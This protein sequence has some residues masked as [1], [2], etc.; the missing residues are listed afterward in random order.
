MKII[1]GLGNPGSE[2]SKTRHNAGF[3]F[4][5]RLIQDKKFET[6]SGS[7]AFSLD[8]KF[9][10]EIAE[11]QVAGEKVIFA[12]PTTFMNL[13]GQAVAKILNFYKAE[14]FDLIVVCDDLDLPLGTG[15]IRLSGSSGGHNGLE[16]I[17][18]ELGVNDFTRLRLGISHHLP[19]DTV[20]ERP[21]EKPE[22]KKF[23]L[24][25]F[26][27]QELDILSQVIDKGVEIIIAGLSK[28]SELKATSFE[29]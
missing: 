26:S 6:S 18:K 21:Y 13:S 23:V 12:K 7:V 11:V 15:R 3:M 27:P 10:A 24:E 29:A 19:G 4:L 9:K 1:V 16:S 22:A 2:Y 20:S 17:I 14:S 28:K 5:D 25:K 8:N